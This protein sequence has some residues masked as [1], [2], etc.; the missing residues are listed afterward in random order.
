MTAR[1]YL[2]NIR[3]TGA[4]IRSAK[5]EIEDKRQDLESLKSPAL[6]D[7]IQSQEEPNA[8]YVV[9]LVDLEDKIEELNRQI[10]TWIDAKD[11]AG[12]QIMQLD[13]PTHQQ[14][15]RMRYIR[16]QRMEEIAAALGYSRAR[17]YALHSDALRAFEDRIM[18]DKTKQ[19]NDL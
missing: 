16:D 12:M 19:D 3:L 1:E 17:I 8:A 5:Q 4:R 9:C 18:K 15:L 11:K 14:I 6:G 13:D 7:R 2:N 10:R